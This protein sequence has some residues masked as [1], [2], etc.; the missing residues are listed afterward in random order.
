MVTRGNVSDLYQDLHT[1]HTIVTVHLILDVNFVLLG[2]TPKRAVITPIFALMAYKLPP[3][4]ANS[5]PPSDID[6]E[7]SENGSP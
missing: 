1:S 4:G 6:M 2:S 3:K 7:D 5:W